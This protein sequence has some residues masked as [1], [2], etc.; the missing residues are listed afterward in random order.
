MATAAQDLQHYQLPSR[1]RATK[2]PENAFSCRIALADRIACLDSIRVVEDDTNTLPC[3]V[4]VYLQA[5]SNSIRRQHDALSLCSIGRDGI[6]IYGLRQ[7][8][9]HQVLRGG[10]G[11][12]ERDHVLIFLPRDSDELEVCWD[13][14]QRAYQNL[15]SIS[16]MSPLVRKTVHWD[17]P[18]FSRTALQ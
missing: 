4:E 12:L 18:R 8:D 3:R 6:R 17:L 15:S 1:I 2:T 14:L 11:K 5:P 7:W 10:W 16:A 13:V 9:R